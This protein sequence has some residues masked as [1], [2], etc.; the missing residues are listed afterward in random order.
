LVS[1]RELTSNWWRRCFDIPALIALSL[2]LSVNNAAAVM[3]ALMGRTGDFVRT[4]KYGKDAVGRC[5]P[6]YGD[7]VS[8]LVWVEIGFG[9]YFTGAVIFAVAVELYMAVPFLM[10]FQV[11][12]LYASVAS[13]TQQ[14]APE[15]ALPTSSSSRLFATGEGE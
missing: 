8:W 1:Q 11:G 14:S 9:V 6:G 7:T 13:L 15:G 12:F 2:G 5:T 3:E 10:L 4:P